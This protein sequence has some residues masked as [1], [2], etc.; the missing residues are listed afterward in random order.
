M[1]GK[2]VTVQPTGKLIVKDYNGEI[3]LEDLQQGV[4]G[5]LEAVP[6]FDYY[7]H[8]DKL[9]RCVAFCNEEGKLSSLPVN[10]VANFLWGISL[11]RHKMDLD[12]TLV[13]NIV[14]VFGDKEFMEAL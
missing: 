12:D 5:Y 8:E 11:A 9:H 4:E 7:M 10:I 3:P 14:I 6:C 13:G 2:M 1:K